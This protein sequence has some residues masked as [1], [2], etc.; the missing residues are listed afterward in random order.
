M[1][2]P[3]QDDHGRR[4]KV[5][6]EQRL[7]SEMQSFFSSTSFQALPEALL[8]QRKTFFS[9]AFITTCQALPVSKK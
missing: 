1:E 9:S 4:Q 3:K 5:M 7:L 6:N 8:G 2:K